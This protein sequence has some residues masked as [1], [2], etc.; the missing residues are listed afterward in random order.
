MEVLS[1]SV[2]HSRQDKM[3]YINTKGAESGSQCIFSNCKQQMQNRYL[4]SKPRTNL[5]ASSQDAL[6]A[7]F[8][9]SKCQKAAEKIMLYSPPHQETASGVK[10]TPK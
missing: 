7:I 5:A 2:L 8:S 6:F 1:S 4:N 3:T 9:F 10:R